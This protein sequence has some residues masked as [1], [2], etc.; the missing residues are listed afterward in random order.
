MATRSVDTGEATENRKSTGI[1]SAEEAIKLAA[2]A[3]VVV[4]ED[5]DEHGY[6]WVRDKTALIGVTLTIVSAQEVMREWGLAWEI[7]AIA[8]GRKPVVF[9]DGSS[10]IAAQL[11]TMR[12]KGSLKTPFM[13]P[14]GLRVS[15]Y[16]G[17]NGQDSATFYLDTTS[18]F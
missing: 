10:G 5:V 16:R 15:R 4:P 8:N 3:S 2:R 17:P 1:I 11:L 9:A 12:E 6:E 13:V 7:R 18:Q 14:K